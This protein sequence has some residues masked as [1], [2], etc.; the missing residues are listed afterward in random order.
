M[1]RA[2]AENWLQP[3]ENRHATDMSGEL[4]PRS[5]LE[6]E[7]EGA[8]SN[9]KIITRGSLGYNEFFFGGTMAKRN[10]NPAQCTV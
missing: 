6:S 1:Q 10:M 9:L 2:C 8:G 5:I 7:C 3:P 4:S